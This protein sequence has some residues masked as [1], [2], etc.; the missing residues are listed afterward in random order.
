MP[1]SVSRLY[2]F[3]DDANNGVPITAIRVDAE[4]NQLV[5]AQ[6]QTLLVSASAPSAPFNGEFWLDSTNK[7]LKQYRN[8]EWVL[9]GPVHYGATAPTTMQLGDI[10]IDSSGS[11]IVYKVRNKGNAAWITLIQSTD[12]T[13]VPTGVGME[14][15][16]ATPPTG[17]LLQDG[18]AISRTTYAALFAIVGTTF[19]IGDGSTTFNLPTRAGKIPVGYNGSDSDYNAVGKTGGSKTVTITQANLPAAD[20]DIKVDGSVVGAKSAGGDGPNLGTSANGGNSHTVKAALGGSG[21]ALD[22]K[23][24]YITVYWIIKT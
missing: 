21:T 6:N 22:V 5:L 4:V 7:V 1:T 8:S 20:L 2:N 24:P 23:N 15:Y 17:W 10:W 11:E 9:M 16:T 12:S 19:G 14:W 13:L 3:V 18:S